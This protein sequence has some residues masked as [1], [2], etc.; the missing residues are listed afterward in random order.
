VRR[1]EGE[2][3][4]PLI[5]PENAGDKRYRNGV[6]G[7]WRWWILNASI[8]TKRGNEGWLAISVEEKRRRGHLSDVGAQKDGAWHS[9]SGSATGCLEVGDDVGVGQGWKINGPGENE[10]EKE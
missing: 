6:D 4:A 10:N 2:T 8:I 3:R 9:R 5:G 7:Q 1:K